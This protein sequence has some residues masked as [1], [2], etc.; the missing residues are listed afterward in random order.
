LKGSLLPNAY[1]FFTQLKCS[2]ITQ[3]DLLTTLLFLLLCFAVSPT[4]AAAPNSF[5]STS[6]L[7]NISASAVP[8]PPPPPPPPLIIF[9]PPQ[10]PPPPSNLRHYTAFTSGATTDGSGPLTASDKH[11]DC[12]DDFQDKAGYAH[13][14]TTASTS[15]TT[16][17][18][19]SAAITA[20]TFDANTD[21]NS[22]ATTAF[23]PR[24]ATDGDVGCSDDVVDSVVSASAA[25]TADSAAYMSYLL[26]N[27][28]KNKQQIWM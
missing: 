11:V 8:L 14:A 1:T 23:A 7:S 6:S 21:I 16:T 12:S 13:A 18:S 2:I 19:I 9:P 24:T 10:P 4:E 20:S 27:Q 17:A 25:P 22:A 3:V 15:A 5:A 28:D 26:F